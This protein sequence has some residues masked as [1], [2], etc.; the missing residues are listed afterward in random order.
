MKYMY[1]V[2]SAWYRFNNGMET[3]LSKSKFKTYIEQITNVFHVVYCHE[4]KMTTQCGMNRK[5]TD[6]TKVVL[7]M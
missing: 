1:K 5:V 2:F 7:N 4:P 3:R 6:N